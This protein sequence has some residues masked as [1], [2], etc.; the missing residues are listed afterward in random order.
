MT[1]KVDLNKFPV[2]SEIGNDYE[3]DV[4]YIGGVLGGLNVYVY[5]RYVGRFGK[6]RRRFLYKRTFDE[7]VWEFNYV[8]MAKRAVF[9]YEE[10]ISAEMLRKEQYERGIEAFAEW[11]GK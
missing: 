9:R 6:D 5:E 11:D 10:S 8:G 3:V 4:C 1:H 2:T 7:R